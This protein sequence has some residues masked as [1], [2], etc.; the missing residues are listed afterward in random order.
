MMGTTQVRFV[1]QGDVLRTFM[2][3]TSHVIYNY[4]LCRLVLDKTMDRSSV[5]GKR[6]VVALHPECA[7]K[8]NDLPVLVPFRR[9]MRY[10]PRH[11]DSTADAHRLM[12]HCL[13]YLAWAIT[14]YEWSSQL[15]LQAEDVAV[16]LLADEELKN[17]AADTLFE[18]VCKILMLRPWRKKFQWKE[19]R[20]LLSMVGES[21]YTGPMSD[22]INECAKYVLDFPMAGG[23]K[24]A[25]VML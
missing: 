15:L 11:P 12:V 16:V 17:V 23:R 18:R 1:T 19:V 7:E 3:S 21:P 13:H 22:K 24:A 14:M 25:D 9:P 6:S 5:K 10:P 20:E 4:E 8:F 2:D